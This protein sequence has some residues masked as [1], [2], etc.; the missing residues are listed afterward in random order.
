MAEV[1]ASV[2][3]IASFGIVLVN[4]LYKFGC[5][6]SSARE[7]SAR[8]GDRVDDYVTILEI[9]A[10][11]LEDEAALISD[12]AS[13]MVDKLCDQSEN[14]FYDIK[15]ILPVRRNDGKLAWHERIAWNFRKAK[16]EMLL[17]QID[18]GKK[19]ELSRKMFVL[20]S[21]SVRRV[22]CTEQSIREVSLGQTCTK[23]VVRWDSYHVTTH[24]KFPSLYIM[25][26]YQ[27]SGNAL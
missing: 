3:G 24:N 25:H 2:V 18:E 9:L 17:G 6:V 5:N 4:T 19:V 22:L 27:L 20:Q 12:K 15:D 14:L 21:A 26:P 7:Q 10:G 23:F 13:A 11:L 1:A 16:V 8:I